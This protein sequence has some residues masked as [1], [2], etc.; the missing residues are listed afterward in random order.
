VVVY[1]WDGAVRGRL[2][3]GDRLRPDAREVAQTFRRRGVEVHVVSGDSPAAARWAAGA[4]GADG[5]L[6][7]VSPAGKADFIAR[8][9]GEGKRV[10]MIGDGMNDAPALARADLGI[11]LGT[12]TDLAMRSAAMVLM[13]GR[14]GGVLDAFDVVRRARGVIRQN[15]FWS[16]FYNTMGIA[17][18]AAGL[19]NPVAAAGAMVLSSGFVLGNT[20][21]LKRSRARAAAGW[22]ALF[23]TAKPADAHAW[24]ASLGRTAEDGGGRG[25]DRSAGTVSSGLEIQSAP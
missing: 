23:G 25:G 5:W 15:L 12:G 6:G 17:L 13:G 24:P 8:L 4:V 16:F 18:A 2:I 19:L 10:A 9:Q 22:S 11:A 14:L 20:L 7:E 1:G 3:F 21:R